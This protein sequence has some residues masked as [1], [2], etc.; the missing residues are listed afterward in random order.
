MEA[1]LGAESRHRR[2]L[3]DAFV[4][5]AWARRLFLF[6][7]TYQPDQPSWVD[8][9]LTLLAVAAVAVALAWLLLARPERLLKEDQ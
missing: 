7:T 4:E 5:H 1:G 9:R 2:L 8:N 6:T 3:P